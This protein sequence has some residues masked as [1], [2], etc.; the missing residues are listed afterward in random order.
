[1]LEAYEAHWGA[2]RHTK[3]FLK[4]EAYSL[5]L[6]C[7]Y[8]K[9]FYS[10]YHWYGKVRFWGVRLRCTRRIEAY[11]GA[12]MSFLNMRLTVFSWGAHMKSHF[13]VTTIDIGEVRFWGVRLSCT[14]RIEAYRGAQMSFLNMRL[15]V[16][17]WGARMKSHFLVTTIDI[18]EAGF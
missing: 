13:I 8:E 5:G 17:S 14:R 9:S 12:Q 1:M 10:H 2:Q 16:F 11:K 3:I 4:F 15:T 7:T 18:V 6:R